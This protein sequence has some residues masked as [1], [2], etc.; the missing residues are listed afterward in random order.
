MSSQIT[1]N[2][3]TYNFPDGKNISVIGDVITVDGKRFVPGED[4]AGPIRDIEI[5]WDGPLASLE[6][7]GVS[8]VTCGDVQGNVNAGGSVDCGAVGGSVDAGGSVRCGDVG[9]NVDAGGSVKCKSIKGDVD[10]GG[11][12]RGI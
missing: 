7:R 1:V 8:K 6:V 2:G 12:V 11:S 3:K 10:A 5:K 4:D 9:K